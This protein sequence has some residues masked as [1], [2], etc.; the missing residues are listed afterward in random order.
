MGFTTAER[1]KRAMLTTA[2]SPLE[3]IVLLEM[4]YAVD[5]TAP[6][7]S[8]GHERLA[9]VL[10]KT[11]GTKAATRAVERVL[12]ALRERG[13]IVLTAKP[14][15]GRRAEY[16]LTVL[17][18]NAPLSVRGA[19]RGDDEPNAPRSE[20]G[21]LSDER[22][23]NGPRSGNEWTPVPARMDPGQTGVPPLDTPLSTP[24]TSAG[25]LEEPEIVIAA[26]ESRDAP[27]A[28][29]L[30][31]DSVFARVWAEWPKTTSRKPARAKFEIA[32]RRHPRGLHGLAEDVIAHGR[33]YRT[34]TPEQFV[35][36]L[37]TWLNDERWD[38]PLASPRTD[39]SVA[40]HNMA[41][42]SRYL[43]PEGDTS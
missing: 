29:V 3:R 1:M 23:E 12:S 24:H 15:R 13:L 7:Y 2:L 43:G 27:S 9:L 6:V 5:D 14:H 17:D 28:I 8:W 26:I 35:P 10:A 42:L 16:A 34:H 32:A 19:L 22:D 30:D 33:A 31:I 41:M 25:E 20:R 39:G 4:A 21:A 38:D 18:E 11:P 37:S 36:M 40:D